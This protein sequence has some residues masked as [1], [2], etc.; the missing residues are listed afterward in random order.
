M[1]FVCCPR[2]RAELAVPTTFPS[3]QTGSTVVYYP[4]WT[5]SLVLSV[6]C[7]LC[8]ASLLICCPPTA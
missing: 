7:P 8:Q 1:P 2:C 4:V 3:Q 6:R 5:T